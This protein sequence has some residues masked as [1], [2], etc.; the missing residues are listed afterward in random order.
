MKTEKMLELLKE[1]RLDELEQALR[2]QIYFESS[3]GGKTTKS[4]KLAVIKRLSK[5]LKD[6][7]GGGVGF[8][9]SNQTLVTDSFVAYI[10]NEKL[11]VESDN[12]FMDNIGKTISTI[13][14]DTV[15]MACKDPISTFVFNSERHQDLLAWYKIQK[16][17][18]KDDKRIVVKLENSYF[19][20]K[21]L[22]DAFKLL[23][24]FKI[25][26]TKKEYNPSLLKNN[27]G[28]L[29]V[30]LPIRANKDT[31]E[32]DIREYYITKDSKAY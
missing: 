18:E 21:Y 10:L 20:A 1:T 29:G 14:N 8:N 30:I 12:V 22:I 31:K 26:V 16:T 13:I 28:S 11:P 25:S 15:E 32:K 27:E 9:E 3:K 7:R 5:N 6:R 2:E 4:Q 19:Q 23:Q 17:T 24:E